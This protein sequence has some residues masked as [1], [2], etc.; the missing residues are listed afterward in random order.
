MAVKAG[1]TGV[2][3]IS[4]TSGSEAAVAHVRSFSF[5]QTA[6]TIESTAMHASNT[7][8]TYV[9]GLSTSTLSLEVYWDT[10]DT[11][12]LDFDTKTT[13][14][15]ELYPHGTGSGEKYYSGNGIVT[16]VTISAAFDGMVEASFSIQNNSA[17]TETSIP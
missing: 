16:G 13:L 15:W 5:D 12:Q 8:R 9:A 4:P 11:P 10:D 14:Y 17:V 3:K 2:V 7:H 6:D 1:T